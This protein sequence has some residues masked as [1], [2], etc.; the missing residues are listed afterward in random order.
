MKIS[1]NLATRPFVELRP[2]FKKLRI[3]MAVLGVA[4][5]ALLVGTHMLQKKLDVAQAQ[6]ND[7]ARQTAA[8]RMEK[9]ATERLCWTARTF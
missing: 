6:M 7:I 5:V 9:A 3:V 1:V 4:I 2:Y 8:A